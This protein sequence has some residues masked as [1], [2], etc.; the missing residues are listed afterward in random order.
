[1]TEATLRS[2]VAQAGLGEASVILLPLDGAGPP[3]ELEPDRP[4]MPASMIKVP[5][6]AALAHRWSAGE[7]RPSDRVVVDPANLT[8]NDAASP[9]VAGYEATLE[10]LGRLMLT[11]SDNVATNVL[12]D[13]LDREPINRFC[14]RA[15]L[16]GTAVRRKLSG[17]LPLIDDPRATGRNAH[18]AGDAARLF[19]QVAARGRED[20]LYSTLANQEWNDKLSRG[21]QPGDRFAHKTGDTDE[22]SH[23]GG[24]L[25]LAGGGRFVLVVYAPLPSSSEVDARHAAFMRALRPMLER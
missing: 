17:S 19:A 23:D 14:R 18:P 24:I 6:A 2:L 15:R 12:I 5:V 9:L 16:T 8:A 11:R 25:E 1:M 10:E 4:L 7:L 21:L 22:V 20:W 13:V 3:F